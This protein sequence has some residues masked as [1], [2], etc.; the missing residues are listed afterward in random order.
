MF[1]HCVPVL[2]KAVWVDLIGQG[3][4]SGYGFSQC[5]LENSSGDSKDHNEV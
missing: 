1:P 3:S 5:H 4:R 2:F